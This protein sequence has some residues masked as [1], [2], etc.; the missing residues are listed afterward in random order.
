MTE[1][2]FAE[3]FVALANSNPAVPAAVLRKALT[4]LS[5]EYQSQVADYWEAA[6]KEALRL[7]VLVMKNNPKKTPQQILLRP[8]VRAV[9]R[10]PYLEAAAKS[11]HLIGTAWNDSETL[12]LKHTKAEFKKLGIDWA[13]HL[14]DHDLLDALFGD[15][16]RNAKAMRS[17]FRAAMDEPA[18]AQARLTGIAN[19]AKTR[20]RYS[21][22]VAVWGAS[23]Q[24]RDSAITAAPGLGKMWVAVLDSRTCS[25]CK[26]LHGTVLEPAAEFPADAGAV[27]LG[28]YRNVL[29][30][31]PRHPNCRCVLAIVKLKKPKQT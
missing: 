13:G 15:L 3:A 10:N 17:R 31:P 9:L 5:E 26:A 16:D 8:D 19:D 4:S 2:E 11:K 7:L 22:Q 27:P 20:A 1:R 28:V 24:V 12:T 30:G 23:S 18:H 6:N 29:I 21:T 14:L 25:H